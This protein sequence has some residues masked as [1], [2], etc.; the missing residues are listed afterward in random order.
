MVYRSLAVFPP[1]GSR[2][3]DHAG[4]LFCVT[5]EA[6]PGFCILPAKFV[7]DE[8]TVNGGMILVVARGQSQPSLNEAADHRA[9]KKV[10]L[11]FEGDTKL[12]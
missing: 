7:V 2:S 5:I 10:R 3:R 1:V 9:I 12:G 11:R 6:V 8:R 4:Y